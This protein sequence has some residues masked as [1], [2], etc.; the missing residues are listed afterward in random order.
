VR[1]KNTLDVITERLLH[2]NQMVYKTYFF[3][4][5]ALDWMGCFSN[6]GLAPVS[7]VEGSLQIEGAWPDSVYGLTVLALDS[8]VTSNPE[9][10]A[11]FFVSYGDPATKGDTLLSYFIQLD[12]GAYY[13]VC[14]GI[15]VEPS[16]FIANLKFFMSNSVSLPIA[17][18][19]YNIAG[20]VLLHPVII[21]KDKIN[22]N[23][24]W[25]QIDFGGSL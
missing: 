15:T 9:Y 17:F 14:A 8:D 22:E 24:S 13:L 6:E 23:L 21:E 18:F 16:F 11:D 20:G 4:G 7:G 12:P 3:V 25:S 2:S 19:E 5:F 10:P 1:N